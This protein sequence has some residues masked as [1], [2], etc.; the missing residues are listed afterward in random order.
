M[1]DQIIKTK[2]D[3]K[4]LNRSLKEKEDEL[5]VLIDKLQNECN[6]DFKLINEMYD[7][8]RVCKKCERCDFSK[9]TINH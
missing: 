2:N 1:D 9:T 5:V 4:V 8:Y 6:H 7:S 3:I